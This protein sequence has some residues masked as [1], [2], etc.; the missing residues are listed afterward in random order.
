MLRGLHAGGAS[1][2]KLT[3]FMLV[4]TDGAN[5]VNLVGAPKFKSRS[6]ASESFT[7]YAMPVRHNVT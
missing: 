2:L 7:R 1:Y 3:G 6:L 4:P 5:N